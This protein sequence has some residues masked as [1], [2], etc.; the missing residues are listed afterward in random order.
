[1]ILPFNDVVGLYEEGFNIIKADYFNEFMVDV[2]YV[3]IR[4][5]GKGR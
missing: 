3:K 5:K 2:E 4:E 1:M